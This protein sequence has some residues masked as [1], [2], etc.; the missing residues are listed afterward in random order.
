M[1]HL[2]QRQENYMGNQPKKRNPYNSPVSGRV[3]LFCLHDS[4][5]D[6]GISIVFAVAVVAH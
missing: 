4:M 3:A 1:V 6:P 5:G 2:Y